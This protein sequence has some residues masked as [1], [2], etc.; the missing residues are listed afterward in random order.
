M[1]NLAIEIPLPKGTRFLE[2]NAPSSV[3]VVSDETGVRFFTAFL[4][5]PI[6]DASFVVQVTDSTVTTFTTYARIVW[7]GNQPG[8]YLTEGVSIDVAHQP[9]NWE[10]PPRP[11][12]QLEASATVTGDV[13]TYMIYP[14]NVGGLRMWDVQINTP[15]PEGTT[16]L[17]AQTV[18]PFVARFDGREVSFFT[19]ELARRAEVGPLSFTV[20]VGDQT[21]PVV[22]HVWA[23]WKNVGRKVGRSI[24]PQ[25]DTRTG[26]IIVQPYTWQWVA[27]DMIGDVPFHQYDITSIAFQDEGSDLK[28]VFYTVGS[29]GPVGELLDYTLYVDNDCRSNTGKRVN[30]RG[31]EYF[32]R[33]SH[34]R[35]QAII[36]RWDET[37]QRWRRFGQIK[38]N[39]PAGSKTVVM[40]L[41]Y[42]LIDGVRQFCWVAEARNL[43]KAFSPNPPTEKVPN[44]REQRLTQYQGASAAVAS[45][46]IAPEI[47]TVTGTF[48]DTGDLWRYLPAQSE[49]PPTWMIV[50]FDDSE[51]PSGSVSPGEGDAADLSIPTGPVGDRGTPILVTQVLTQA[52]MILALPASEEYGPVFMRRTFNVPDP[53]A[54]TR[55][56]LDVEYRTAFVAYLNG[57]EVARRG[58]GTPGSPITPDGSNNGRQAGSE[59]IDLSAY[60]PQLVAGTNVLAFYLPGVSRQGSGLPLA[61]RLAWE[62]V[63]EKPAQPESVVVT[64]AVSPPTASTAEST[65]SPTQPAQAPS[66]G[67][68]VSYPKPTLLSPASEATFRAEET[69]V[70]A[71]DAAGDLSGDQWYEVRLWENGTEWR[72]VAQTQNTSWQVPTDYNPGRYGWQVAVVLVQDGKWVKDLSP[73]SD[74]RFFIWEAPPLQGGSE[75]EEKKEEGPS[76]PPRRR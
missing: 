31:V 39:D 32:I 76:G 65:S 58:L 15:I 16:F 57:Q 70:L 21:A 9:L 74:M 1:T 66:S 29:L 3:R 47:E 40:W 53:A 2:A 50:D 11:R 72:G 36:S 52:G 56:T 20:S 75:E 61:P 51:W 30:Y 48:V 12:L 38:A 6:E 44:R 22:T 59:V 55:L 27:S 25:E 43:T 33:Y 24:A 42:A 10:K 37:A 49:P 71:W 7:E 63:R 13:I 46:P 69:V 54:L 19:V 26:D 60:I 67:V 34:K 18:P 45:E 35:G 28:V 5:Q 64:E 68:A 23:T 8:E 4:Y 14:R 62:G 73:P 17:S 41:P